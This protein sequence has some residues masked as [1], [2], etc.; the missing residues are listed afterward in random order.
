LGPRSSSEARRLAQQLATLCRA[1]CG[2]AEQ[3]QEEDA[4]TTEP[5][6][7][8]ET[9]LAKQVVRACQRAIK[10]AVAQPSQA[11]GLALELDAVLTSLRLAQTETAKSQAGP[12]AVVDNVEALSRAALQEVLKLAP[13]PSRALDVLGMT[14]GIAPSVTAEV[15]GQAPPRAQLM[16]GSNRAH[17]VRTFAAPMRRPL[18]AL[19]LTKSEVMS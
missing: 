15:A 12:R 11:I 17:Y 7:E 13:D 18:R 9:E 4:V 8:Q 16:R 3:G 14:S 6:D 2:A 10:T 19:A 1:I 5:L